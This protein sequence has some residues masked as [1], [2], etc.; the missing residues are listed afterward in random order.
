MAE[1]SKVEKELVEIRKLLNGFQRR[2]DIQWL[3]TI[4]FTA[5]MGAL[6]LQAIK[7][8]PW[9]VLLTFFGGF[10]IMIISPYIK[11]EP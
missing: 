6:A 7:A 9:A 1:D 8:P 4:G 5:V 3:Y 2:A 10:V 11:K